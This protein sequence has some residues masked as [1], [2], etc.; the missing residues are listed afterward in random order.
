VAADKDTPLGRLI[1]RQIVESGPMPFSL[2]MQLCL[3]HPEHGFYV[4]SDPI[5]RAGDFVTGPEISQIFGEA[6]G[7]WVALLSRQLPGP[8][9]DLVELGPGRGTLMADLMRSLKRVAPEAG[10]GGPILVEISKRLRAGQARL[11]AAH[12]P[13]WLSEVAE[14]AETGAPLV[15]IANEFFDVLPVR[16]YQKGENGWHER[17]VGLEDGK[18]VWGLDPTPIPEDALPAAVNDAELHARFETRPAADTVMAVLSE[19]IMQ[20]GGALLAIDYGYESTQTGDT[21]QAIAGHAYTD[22]LAC[23]GEAD[24]TAHVDF[25]ALAAAAA[26][27]VAHPVLSQRAF[28]SALGAAERA[29]ALAKA[30]PVRAETVAA[31]YARLTEKDGMGEIFRTMCVSS[32]DLVPY[33]FTTKR[34]PHVQSGQEGDRYRTRSCVDN[35]KGQDRDPS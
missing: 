17:V 18:R 25:E 29:E 30:N 1:D 23:P 22:P 16:Q 11:L 5:G 20:R 21:V 13:V 26:G 27:V 14:L 32:S 6:I 2:F 33:P 31:G 15:V 8:D 34:D 19:K 4:R 10:P 3:T 24:L 28:L 12:S 35:D 9:F 7:L